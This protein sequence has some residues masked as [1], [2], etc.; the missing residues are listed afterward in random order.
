MGHKGEN[1]KLP[2]NYAKLHSKQSEEKRL[3]GLKGG[4]ER[5]WW[6]VGAG[7]PRAATW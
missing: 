7:G 2:P 5:C 4:A 3:R 6:Q 1:N